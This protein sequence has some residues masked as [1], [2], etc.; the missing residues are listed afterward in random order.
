MTVA[1]EPSPSN[2]QG[3]RVEGNRRSAAAG[4]QEGTALSSP[5]STA[6]SFQMDFSIYRNGRTNG[7][8]D[9][10]ANEA[11]NDRGASSRASDEDENG[12]ARKKLRLTKEQSAFLE[13]SFKEHSTL[14]PV[15]PNLSPTIADNA[16]KSC[17][18]KYDVIIH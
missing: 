14:N 13:E 7:K 5:N 3:K 18:K 9:L 1:A 6:S 4:D 16:F 11:E 8:R 15:S 12:L 17:I 10:E 2:G